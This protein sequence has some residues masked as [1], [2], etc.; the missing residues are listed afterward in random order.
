MRTLG[1]VTR[2]IIYSQ[3]KKV[4]TQKCIGLTYFSYFFKLTGFIFIGGGSKRDILIS[5]ICI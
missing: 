5:L 1:T 3:V 4:R 2:L